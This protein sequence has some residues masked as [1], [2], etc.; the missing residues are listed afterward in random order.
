[1]ARIPSAVQTLIRRFPLGFVATVQAD[2][3]PALS[4][5]GT[6]LVLDDETIGFGNIRSPG[7]VENLRANPAVEVN[8]VDVFTRKGARLRGRA[9]ILAAGSGAFA[10][11]LPRYTDTWGDLARRITDIVRIPVEDVRPVTTPPYDDGVT[12]EAMIAL[13]K[14]KFAEF[15]P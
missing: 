12:E 14:A 15:Y 10:D 6:F 8:F 11:L 7:T 4:P 3:A 5:K 1:M 2:G 9:E 13:Y